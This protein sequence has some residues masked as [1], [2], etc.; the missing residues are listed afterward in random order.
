[1]PGVPVLLL[2]PSRVRLQDFAGQW[3]GGRGGGPETDGG[4]LQVAYDCCGA[5]TTGLLLRVALLRK[6]QRPSLRVAPTTNN[7]RRAAPRFCY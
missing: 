1:M 3:H 6:G 7:L 5:V 4:S 2:P